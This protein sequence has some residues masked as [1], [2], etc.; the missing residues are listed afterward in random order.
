MVAPPL[1][2]HTTDLPVLFC[3]RMIFG[4]YPSEV[5]I[6]HLN[7]PR[8]FFSSIFAPAKIN[9]GLTVCITNM[10]A[11]S[12]NMVAPLVMVALLVMVAPPMIT[13]NFLSKKGQSFDLLYFLYYQYGCTFY[14][15]GCA[16]S[17]GCTASYGC[18]TDGSVLHDIAHTS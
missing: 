15:Y 13:L 17:Y 6:S 9:Y 12:I 18:A 5:N 2:I 7:F 14:Q 4:T 8:Q 1:R 16:A 3:I 11:S 10:V